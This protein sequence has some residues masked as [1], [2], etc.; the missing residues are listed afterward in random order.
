MIERQRLTAALLGEGSA[1]EPQ[2]PEERLA[3]GIVVDIRPH[4]LVMATQAGEERFILTEATAFWHGGAVDRTEFKAG[5]EAIV[6]RSVHS[7]WVAERVWSGLARVSGIITGREGDAVHVDA[8]H[9]RGHQ[10]AVIPYRA[11]ERMRVR[12]PMLEPGYLFDAIGVWR[13]GV[14]EALLPATQQPPFSAAEASCRPVAGRVSRHTGGG[15]VVE[16]SV[17]WYDPAMG[18][19]PFADPIAASAGAAY[20]ALDSASDCGRV[21]DRGRSCAP[22]PLMSVGTVLHLRNL[23]GGDGAGEDTA[24]VPVESCAA[25]AS[26]FCDRC[27]TCPDSS[28]VWGRIAELTLASYIA[29]GG[30]PEAGCL[31]ARLTFPSEARG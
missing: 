21:C 31:T 10:T 14:V 24:A 4:L 1:P 25:M 17:T 6:R 30:I 19:S 12:L 11:S 9:N 27:G 5:Q 3:R 22:L 13:D 20:P 16:G 26:Y 2:R 15:G 29:L 18:R 7:R 28:G 8:G 23:C